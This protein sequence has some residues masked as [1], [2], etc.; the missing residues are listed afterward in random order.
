MTT[1]KNCSSVLKNLGNKALELNSTDNQE[2]KG[3]WATGQS[4]KFWGNKGRTLGE[5]RLSALGMEEESPA[6]ENCS[7]G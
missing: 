3:R 5:E 6:E 4:D 7:G 1:A 2:I